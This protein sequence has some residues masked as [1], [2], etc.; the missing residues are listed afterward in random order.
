[1]KVSY[2]NWNVWAQDVFQEYKHT[3]QG[4]T[5]EQMKLGVFGK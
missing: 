1:M 2:N 4:Q 5:S 3:I